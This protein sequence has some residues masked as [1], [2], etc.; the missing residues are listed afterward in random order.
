LTDAAGYLDSIP[1]GGPVAIGGWTPDSM[2]PPTMELAL[3]REDLSLRYFDP[4]RAVIIPAD[5]QAE[6]G[7]ILHPTALPLHPNL[8]KQLS[9]YGIRPEP[10]GAF[11]YYEVGRD[12]IVAALLNEAPEVSFGGEI[13]L[14]TYHVVENEDSMEVIAV[15]RVDKPA[16]ADRSFFVHLLDES[17]AIVSQD[18][19]RGAPAAH[20]QAGDIIIQQHAVGLPN[21]PGNFGIR[22]GVYN[23]R[24]GVRLQTADGA[25]SLSVSSTAV[26]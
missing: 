11:T 17:G 20:W 22:L 18:D 10:I 24:S 9:T 6:S 21:A 8:L 3:R 13:S 12:A 1:E 4:G 19:A 5:D 7:R 23:P 16:A 14:L 25:D 26:Q 15:W 2:D